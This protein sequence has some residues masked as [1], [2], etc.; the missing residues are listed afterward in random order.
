M[1]ENINENSS[2]EKNELCTTL[3]TGTTFQTWEELEAHL[4]RY[5]LQEGFSYKKTRVDYHLSQDKMKCLTAE[6]KKYEIK[7]RTYEFNVTRPKKENP[8]GITSVKL[9][10]NHEMNPLVN[11]MAPKFRKFTQPMLNDVEFYVK[12]ETT[13]ARQIYPLL[14]AKFPDH[15][16]F[17]KDLYNAIQKFKVGQKDTIENDTANLLHYLYDKKQQDPEWFFKF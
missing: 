10:H 14:H 2:N 15:L 8:I 7:R 17:K 13:S 11:E 5:A 9:E 6:Q 4:E 3:V 1:D 16:I 12:H